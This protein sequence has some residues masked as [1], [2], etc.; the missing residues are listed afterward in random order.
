MHRVLI[1]TQGGT[2]SAETIRLCLPH[3]NAGS[4][5]GCRSHRQI[6]AGFAGDQGRSRLQRTIPLRATWP[7]SAPVPPPATQ[8]GRCLTG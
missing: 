3:W 7:S 4:G 5:N 6:F 1:L 8:P 2:V